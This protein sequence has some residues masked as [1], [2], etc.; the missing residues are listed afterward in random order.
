VKRLEERH[1][2]LRLETKAVLKKMGKSTANIKPGLITI[3]DTAP[4]KDNK[5]SSSNSS[6]NSKK[7]KVEPKDGDSSSKKAKAVPPSKKKSQKMMMTANGMRPRVTSQGNK[8]MSIPDEAFPEFCRRIGPFGTG[9]RMKLIN[10]FA[11]DYPETSIRQ[12]TLKLGE[13][14]CKEPPA[15]VDMTGRKVRAFMFYLRPRFYKYLYPKDRPDNWEQ[16]AALDDTLW[17]MEKEQKRLKKEKALKKAAAEAAAAADGESMSSDR[18]LAS[19]V[20]PSITGDDD[21]DETEDEG[22]ES[23]VK[24]LKVGD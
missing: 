22:G 13:I 14:T 8:R 10:Q 7:R 18:D 24:R 1:R 17:E 20:S 15:C 11:E 2:L 16:F 3:S 6:S 23:A 19:N 12:V 21:G 9:E 4:K 5:L